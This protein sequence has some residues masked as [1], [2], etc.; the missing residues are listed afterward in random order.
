MPDFPDLESHVRPDDHQALRLWLRLLSCTNL[1]EN[2]VRS[3]LR[4]QFNTTLPRFDMM[5]Q[6]DRVPEGLKMS[7]LSRYMMVTNG[8]ITGITD[9]L[10]KE[11]LVERVKVVNDRR[12][13]L[14]RLTPAGKK[15]FAEMAA[16][17]EQWIQTLFSDLPDTDR[18]TLHGLLGRLKSS[19]H[20]QLPS[21]A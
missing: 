11:G 7:D 13:S 19:I 1:I 5:A 4:A 3:R 8:N 18:T 2:E 16:V 9:Q 20:S 15:A 6:L 21:L 14:I 10:E 12:S 17:H